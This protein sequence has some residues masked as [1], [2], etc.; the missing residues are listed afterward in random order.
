MKQIVDKLLAENIIRPSNSPYAS[1]LVL[2]RKKSGEV[3]MC[4]DY[5]PLNKITVR[6][7]YPLPLIET[8]LEHLCGKRFFSLLD[9]KSGFHQVPM[10]EESI[11]YTSFVTPDGQF[12]YLKMPFGL[13]NTPS[14]FQRFINSISREFIDDGRVVV[15]LDDIIIASTDLNSHLTT[16]RSVLEKIKQNNLELRL[17]KCKFTHEEIEYLGYKAN[18]NG[19]QPSDRHIQALTNY[20]MPTN[21]ASNGIATLL[22]AMESTL[23]STFKLSLILDT[24]S[25]YNI[26]V[27]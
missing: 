5:R 25:S 1:A 20:P 19:I 23:H 9:L 22:L 26:R 4:V 8:C 3:R 21:L 6:D 2:V 10:R 24:Q 15:Y 14:E 11:P 13:R 16:L 12:E 17:D 27:H 18:F 7:N